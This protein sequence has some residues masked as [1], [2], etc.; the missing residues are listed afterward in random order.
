ME[1]ATFFAL[2]LSLSLF[3]STCLSDAAQCLINA[4]NEVLE[5]AHNAADPI[6]KAHHHQKSVYKN[7]INMQT[8]ALVK[9]F[10]VVV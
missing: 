5:G 8:D 7:E 9:R 10:V 2:S 3:L 4:R 6:I 1:V